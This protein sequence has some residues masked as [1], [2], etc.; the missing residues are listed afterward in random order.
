MTRPSTALLAACAALACNS[1]RTP[2]DAPLDTTTTAQLP[3]A[4]DTLSGVAAWRVTPIGIGPVLAGMTL[5]DATRSIGAVPAIAPADREC[6]VVR[7][8]GAPAGVSFM[9]VNDRIVRVDIDSGDVSTAVGARL[10]DTESRIMALYGS[11]VTAAPHKYT[12]GKYLTVVP[13]G[14]DSSRYRLIF[15]T[16]GQR[17]IRFRSGQ[18]PEVAWVE[19][20][21]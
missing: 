6:S 9:V 12:D 5:A 1:E 3:D 21:A 20:C 11:H 18:L 4:T 13:E 17:V 19:R 7:G 14:A 8:A 10:G 15:E 16:D 2:L